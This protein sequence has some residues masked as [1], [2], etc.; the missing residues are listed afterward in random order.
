MADAQK[1]VD[2]TNEIVAEAQSVLAIIG[3]VDPAIAGETAATQ[4][5]LAILAGLVT[6]ALTAYAAAAD[7]PITPETIAA[8]MSN[9][10]PL[11]APDVV[12]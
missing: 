4:G 3:A 9:P 12:S 11:S 10:A 8:L 6:K 2:V 5:V 1:V 7:T